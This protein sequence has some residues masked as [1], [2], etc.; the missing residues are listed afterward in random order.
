MTL[1]QLRNRIIKEIPRPLSEV[2]NRSLESFLRL[3]HVES[4]NPDNLYLRELSQVFDV[5]LPFSFLQENTTA[6]AHKRE[7]GAAISRGEE[8]PS[9]LIS[10]V[11]AGA[12]LS[13]WGAT[14]SFVP[15]QK[16]PTPDIEATW[17]NGV[18]L[19]VEVARGDT[20]FLHKAVQNGINAFAGALQP[21]DVA[22]N[23]IA[24]IAD[25]SNSKDLDEMFEAAS[26]LQPGQSAEVF[27]KWYVR[28]VPLSQRDD[29]VAAHVIELFG[30][31]WW[32]NNDP[33]YGSTSTLIGSAENPVVQLRSLVPITSYMSPVIRKAN[34]GQRWPGNPYLIA[35]DVSDLPRAHERIID[36][37]RGY[38]EIWNHVSAVLLFEPRFYIGFERK[39]WVV[40]IHRNPRANI[41]L[42]EHFNTVEQ[43]RCS[44]NFTLTK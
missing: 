16:T 6:F 30:P 4:W 11:H 8:V 28:A 15:C 36:E 23:V 14:V 21:H 22:W 5:G 12:L 27:G 34:S 1:D 32:P 41:Q 39:E 31:D 38:F 10:E 3:P 35:L 2:G 40:S 37:L 20:R 25:A 19:D 42:P 7:I 44:I 33:S 17:G 29:V 9:S 26:I 43:E 13:N 24:F 18:I